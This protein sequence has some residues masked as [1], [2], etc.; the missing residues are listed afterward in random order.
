MK[1]IAYLQMKNEASFDEKLEQLTGA[2][3]ECIDVAKN[4]RQT[5]QLLYDKQSMK[6]LYDDIEELRSEFSELNNASGLIGDFLNVSEAWQD[7]RYQQSSARYFCWDLE[8][9]QV[10]NVNDSPLAEIAERKL[11]EHQAHFLFINLQWRT[12]SRAFFYVFKDAFHE[13]EDALPSNILRID[14]VNDINGLEIWLNDH[15]PSFSLNDHS[16]FQKTNFVWGRSNQQIYRELNTGY[17]WYFDS[18]HKGNKLHYEV[19]NA[20]GKH[21]GEADAE[22][23]LKE[24]TADD[25]KKLSL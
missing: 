16:R 22:G 21:L 18:Y 20:E 25:N 24:R 2:L 7:S 5:L 4:N 12:N 14:H 13:H 10:F 11:E 17:L 9:E 1:T 23:R 8:Q 15:L 3:K 6:K 19:F